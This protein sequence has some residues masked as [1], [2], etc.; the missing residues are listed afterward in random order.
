VI[1]WDDTIDGEAGSE[2]GYIQG[3]A[4]CMDVGVVFM[5]VYDL[6]LKHMPDFKGHEVVYVGDE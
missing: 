4:D 5:W 3:R 2:F 6:A 1:K